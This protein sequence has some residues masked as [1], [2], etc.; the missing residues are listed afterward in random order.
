MPSALLEA[1]VRSPRELVRSVSPPAGAAAHLWH[2]DRS[3]T[4]GKA[5]L[6]EQRLPGL[7]HCS[8]TKALHTSA[9]LFASV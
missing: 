5:R 9:R 2:V 4:G 1:V 7:P 8:V 3:W 6:P